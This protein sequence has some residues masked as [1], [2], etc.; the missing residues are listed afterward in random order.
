MIQGVNGVKF[1]KVICYGF[2]MLF[3]QCKAIKRWYIEKTKGEKAAI[4]YSGKVGEDWA[5]YI[6]R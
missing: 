3:M 1:Y 2:Y 5:K 6:R 4:D